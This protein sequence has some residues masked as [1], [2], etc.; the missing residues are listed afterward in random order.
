MPDR[1]SWRSHSF[2]ALVS[3]RDE[4][5]LDP[6][7]TASR[8]EKNVETR[9]IGVRAAPSEL[10]DVERRVLAHERILQALIGHL[11]DDDSD[12]LEQLKARFGHSHNLGQFEQDYVST[13]DYGD[14]FIR[15]I[16]REVDRRLRR[17]SP[18]G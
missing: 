8:C 9:R 11:A 4:A 15:S 12:I 2:S 16:E 6:D 14:Q 1:S 3:A 5:R 17:N 10:T 13:D 7:E 18:P